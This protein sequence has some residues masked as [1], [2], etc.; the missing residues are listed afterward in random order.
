MFIGLPK[1]HAAGCKSWLMQPSLR[2]R[3]IEMGA[4]EPAHLDY[5]ALSAH[6]CMRPSAPAR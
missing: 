3:A 2:R 6:K 5:V 1:A 4:L